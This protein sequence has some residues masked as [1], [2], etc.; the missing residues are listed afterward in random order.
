MRSNS[1]T[2]FDAQVGCL[3]TPKTK[4]RLDVF[5]L[6]NA[7]TNDI[8]YYDTSRLRGEPLGVSRTPISTRARSEA[9]G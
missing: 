2:V 9:S 6:F 1:S 5:N 3:I 7:E 4:L 8:T